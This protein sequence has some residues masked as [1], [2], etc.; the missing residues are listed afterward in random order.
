MSPTFAPGHDLVGRYRI[1]E[2][3][4]VGATAEVYLAEDLSLQRRVV[5]KVLLGELSAYEDV[6]RSF[7][8]HIIRAAT[9]NHPQVVRVFDGGQESGSIFMVTEY[10]SGG[11][12]EDVL[13]SG[14]VL[15]ADD[16]A[17]LGRD[18]SAALAYLHANGFVH[19]SL[20][21]S[22]LLFDE[23]GF[24]RVSDIALAGLGEMHRE[25]LSFDDVRYLS[26]EQAL[27]GVAVDKSDVYALALILYESVTGES[28]FES[29]TAELML[30][31]RIN[32]PL[33]VRAEL[34]TLDMVLAQA[35]VPDPRVRLDAEQFASRLSAVASDAAPLSVRPVRA[36]VPL[37]ARFPASTPRSSIGFRPPSADEIVGATAVVPIIARQ[38]PAPQPPRRDAGPGA[39]TGVVRRVAPPSRPRATGPIETPPQR[40]LLFFVLALSLVLVAVVAAVSWQLG[41]FATKHTVPSLIGMNYQR[42]ASQLKTEG[43]AL[44]VTQHSHS[45]TAPPNDIVSQNPTPGTQASSGQTVD[46]TVSE[47]PV[48]V[49]LPS[50]LGQDCV[51]ATSQLAT[52]HVTAQCP[53]SASVAS[54]T[55]PSGRVA[56]VIYK[57]TTNP[58][59]VPVGSTVTLAL[60]TGPIVAPTTTTAPTT[61]VPTTT[62]PPTTAPPTTAPTTTT[63]PGQGPRAVP[64]VVGDSRSQVYA[65]MRAAS[66]YFSTTGPGS[67]SPAWTVVVAQTPAAGTVVPWHSSV[68]L[69]VK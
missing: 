57:N 62:V 31:R 61:T 29:A 46:V 24:V 30:R 9:L 58:T 66:L 55:I 48:V 41:F 26:P 35:A 11:A 27:G 45:S 44:S 64:N 56:S 63:A 6:R 69:Q 54:S 1:L 23:D 43:L 2:L 42:A 33:P 40:R 52:V 16:T 38:Y 65:A 59:S 68:T 53:S 34:G 13:R 20:T 4:G 15:G 8:D 22:K 37:L 36:G 47:G 21:P 5:V 49:V 18:V 51:S 39:P 50:V 17:R 7:R 14:R 10:L 12:L 3:L 60:S 32:T 19:G 28:P 67:N 25:Q